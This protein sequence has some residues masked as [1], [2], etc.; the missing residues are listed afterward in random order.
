MVAFMLTRFSLP[1]GMER[2]TEEVAAILASVEVSDRCQAWIDAVDQLDPIQALFGNAGAVTFVMQHPEEGAVRIEEW[3]AL[4]ASL[5][6]AFGQAD[7]AVDAVVEQIIA[8]HASRSGLERSARGPPGAQV[9]V[10]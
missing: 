7:E 2:K 5:T 9:F 4:D 6:A 3:T 8:S 1:L 10:A